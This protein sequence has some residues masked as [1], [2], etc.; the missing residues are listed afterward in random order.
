MLID[1]DGKLVSSSYIVSAEVD[2]RHYMNGSSSAL[3]VKMADGSTIRK[4]HGFGFDA[5][6]TLKR[7]KDAK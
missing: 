4:E 2:T 7:I 3:V 6:E 5:Y 1:I